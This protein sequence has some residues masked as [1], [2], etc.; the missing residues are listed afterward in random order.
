MPIF[1]EKSDVNTVGQYAACTNRAQPA[2]A[3]VTP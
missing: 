2:T 1:N 3:Q